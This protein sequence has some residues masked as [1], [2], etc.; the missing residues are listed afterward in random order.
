MT[1]SI[2]M[3][4]GLKTFAALAYQ[5][6][7]ALNKTIESC[8]SPRTCVR[9]LSDVLDALSE[10]L[11]SLTEAVKSTTTDVDLSIL[12]LPLQRCG[13]ACNDF[14]EEILKLLSQSAG[15]RTSFE[16]WTELKYM[17]NNIDGFKQLLVGYKSTIIIALFDLNV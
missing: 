12:E 11:F 10:V 4:L 17:G 6:S 13:S 7:I 16:G 8:Q 15:S 9:A 14:E 5:S 1:D 3:P 2:R